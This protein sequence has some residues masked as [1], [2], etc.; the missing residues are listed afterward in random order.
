LEGIIDA[1]LH[2]KIDKMVN[3][4]LEN[5][6]TKVEDRSVKQQREFFGM[7]G[8]APCHDFETKQTA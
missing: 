6:N 1:I 3:A 8:G 7:E 2:Q 4:G 5:Q